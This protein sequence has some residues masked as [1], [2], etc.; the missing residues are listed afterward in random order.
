MDL[1]LTSSTFA[2]SY[3]VCGGIWYGALGS[4]CILLFSVLAI[5]IKANAAGAHTFP[6]I[7]PSRHGHITHVTYL[8]FGL[9]TNLLVGAFWCERVRRVFLGPAGRGGSSKGVPFAIDH[10]LGGVVDVWLDQAYWQR[11]IASL[12]ET[13]VKAYI[14]GGIAWCGIP[15][16]F[17]TAMGLA[18][19]ALTGSPSNP[20]SAAQNSAGLSASATAITFTCTSTEL[21]AISSLLTF[22][23]YKT[24]IRPQATNE[25][26]VKISHYSIVIYAVVLA[27]FCSILDAVGINLTWILTILAIIV[28][29]A[30]IPPAMVLMWLRTSTIA[31]IAAPWTALAMSL[32]TWL[33]SSRTRSGSITVAT[34]GVV[35]NAWWQSPTILELES[36]SSSR[37]L[38]PGMSDGKDPEKGSTSPTVEQHPTVGD[39][40]GGD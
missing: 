10:F 34:T 8:F 26:L 19:A 27:V 11:A 31:T 2:Y 33:V 38:E 13:A 16:A 5:K 1:V 12:P 28:G 15:F 25:D 18:C 7:V 29:G 6:E 24:Y 37:D 40:R 32:T 14:V 4:F 9:A 35:Y 3:G 21:A 39:G 17:T 23:V 22:D 20:L 30:A 36:S